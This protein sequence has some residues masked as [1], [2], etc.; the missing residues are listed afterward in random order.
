MKISKDKTMCYYKNTINIK[1][2][3]PSPNWLQASRLKKL[4]V[5]K[6]RTNLHELYGE[7][8]KWT[9]LYFFGEN[10]M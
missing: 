7:T 2:D 8:E 4:M 9:L 10:N 5:A 3:H 6:L 1:L